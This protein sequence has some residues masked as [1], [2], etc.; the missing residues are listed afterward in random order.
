M[1]RTILPGKING[2]AQA[3]ASKS[4]LHRLLICAALSDG[5]TVIRHGALCEDISATCRCLTALGASVE[6]RP[7]E[8]IVRGIEAD[9][10]DAEV[11][12]ATNAIYE[13]MAYP[14]TFPEMFQVRCDD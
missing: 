13:S 4:H 5:E 11:F 1:N 2:G 9:V 8:I 6:R 10:D 12:E 14:G 3:V 7:G